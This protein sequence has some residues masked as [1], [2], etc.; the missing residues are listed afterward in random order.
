MSAETLSN[1]FDDLTEV[2][3]EMGSPERMEVP[4]L[5]SVDGVAVLPSADDNAIRAPV[6]AHTDETTPVDLPPPAP[7]ATT[8]S[9]LFKVASSSVSTRQIRKPLGK[10][11]QQSTEVIASK[12][13]TTPPVTSRLARPSSLPK[14]PS[15]AEIKVKPAFFLARLPRAIYAPL[16]SYFPIDSLKSLSEVS[17]EMY[18]MVNSNYAHWSS[19]LRQPDDPTSDT[20][21]ADAMVKIQAARAAA[22]DALVGLGDVPALIKVEDLRVLRTY[23]NPP[24]AVLRLSKALVQLLRFSP[25]KGAG[26][27]ARAAAGDWGVI[28][29]QFL[30][31]KTI[32]RALKTAA[33]AVVHVPLSVARSH[34]DEIVAVAC[35]PDLDE[36]KFKRVCAALVPT[37]TVTRKIAAAINVELRALDVTL[38]YK[39]R[40]TVSHA[41]VGEIVAKLT[42]DHA[43][44]EASPATSPTHA[45]AKRIV[46]KS[47]VVLKVGTAKAVAAAATPDK[48]PALVRKTTPRP[49]S[50]APRPRLHVVASPATIAEHAASSS[51]NTSTPRASLSSARGTTTTTTTKR[52]A[53]DLGKPA[54]V[55]ST[56]KKAAAT[57]LAADAPSSSEPHVPKRTPLSARALPSR[58]SALAKR[59][60]T[61]NPAD[62]SSGVKKAVSATPSPATSSMASLRADLEAAAK[63]LQSQAA[64]LATQTAHAAALAQTKGELESQLKQAQ[65][66]LADVKVQWGLSQNQVQTQLATLLEV[67]CVQETLQFR[68]SELAAVDAARSAELDALALEKEQLQLEVRTAHALATQSRADADE[69]AH[70]LECAESTYAQREADLRESLRAAADADRAALVR[71]MDE[72]KVAMATLQAEHHAEL[73][74]T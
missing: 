50:A 59:T 40:A 36:I 30:D 4:V 41:D 24:P 53:V 25:P 46:P 33:D 70:V 55:A 22:R 15:T 18:H 19:T 17:P 7:T 26:V 12:V 67:K 32:I 65:D 48:A 64:A 16:F 66:D 51:S 45:K 61:L 14:A 1:T 8:V 35:G 49:V 54:V 44:P 37:L 20:L 68:L 38:L 5:P 23:R 42:T 34:L 62:G 63:E 43:Q 13:N 60:S 71:E 72:L 69:K 29:T 27:D 2:I 11:Q 28:K 10:Q 73:E 9:K 58:T 74:S 52:S 56:V 6:A 21:L 3:H 57:T 31:L 39:R 47:T